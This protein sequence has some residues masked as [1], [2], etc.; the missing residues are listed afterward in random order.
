[1]NGNDSFNR[2]QEI[3]IKQ[4]G[5]VNYLLITVALTILLLQNNIWLN[6]DLTHIQNIFLNELNFFLLISVVIGIIL[7]LNRLMSFRITARIARQRGKSKKLLNKSNE[8]TI[9]ISQLREKT[10]RMDCWTW[11]LFYF[12]LGTFLTGLLALFIM[13]YF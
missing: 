10:K 2:W 6:K 12:Q 7:A 4:F 8:K 5:Y 1:M 9:S 3:R 13:S 11:I